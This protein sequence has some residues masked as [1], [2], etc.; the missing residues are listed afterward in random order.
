MKKDKL[1]QEFEGLKI[2]NAGKIF[3]GEM[4]DWCLREKYEWTAEPGQPAG[5]GHMDPTGQYERLFDINPTVN[6]TI[7][8]DTVPNIPKK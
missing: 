5:V 1:F 7:V 2:D 4:G 3:G 8:N 6:D